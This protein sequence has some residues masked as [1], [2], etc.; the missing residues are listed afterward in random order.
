MTYQLRLGIKSGYRKTT[1]HPEQVSVQAIQGKRK[2]AII[3]HCSSS[4]I[5]L[6]PTIAITDRLGR[7][8]CGIAPGNNGSRWQ[9]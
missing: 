9:P 7:H 1:R 2:D 6:T 3:H 8:A 5:V 4:L